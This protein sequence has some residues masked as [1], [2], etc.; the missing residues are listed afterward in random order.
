MQC[1][2]GLFRIGFILHFHLIFLFFNLGLE[3][4]P[5]C[6]FR[7][8]IIDSLTQ[9]PLRLA[10]IKLSES[11]YGAVSDSNGEFSIS[12]IT[13]GFYSLR[14]SLVGY[15]TI[16]RNK[17]H[18]FLDIY[19][20]NFS[21]RETPQF[22][23]TV[24]VKP[25]KLYEQELNEYVGSIRI[26]N[27][28]LQ[29][30]PGNLEDIVKS[31]SILP[32]VA[33][34]SNYYNDL[35]VNGG[36]PSENLFV[37]DGI[38]LSNINHFGSQSN[39]GGVLSYVNMDY[40]KDISFSSGNFSSLYGD[41][42]SSVTEI[43]LQNGAS[44]HLTGKAVVSATQ[45]ALNLNGLISEE[46]SFILS[47]RRS[48]LDMVFKSY[49]FSFAPEYYDFLAKMNFK[50]NQSNNLSLLFIGVLDDFKI[51]DPN[52]DMVKENSRSIGSK[53]D[54]YIAGIAFRSIFPYGLLDLNFNTNFVNYKAL[55]S[56]NF[57][58][59]TNQIENS[60][61]T[62]LI[63][64]FSKKSEL[65][66]GLQ[67][68]IINFRTDI[69]LNR[70]LT[71][72]NEVL[73][74]DSIKTANDYFKSG[75]YVQYNSFWSEKLKVNLGLRADYFDGI[76]EDYSLSPRFHSQYYFSD[77]TSFSLGLGIYRQTPEY[78][79]ISGNPVNK[80]LKWMTA[81][82]L[83]VELMHRLEQGISIKLGGFYKKYYNYPA[84]QLRPYLVMINTGAGVSGADD[85][86]G[87]FG[88][89]PLLSQGKGKVR[90]AELFIQ[91]SP[92]Q[93]SFWGSLSLTYCKVDFSGLDYVSH[94]GSF[95]QR[96]NLVITAGYL[97]DEN[98]E[99]DAKFRYATGTPYTP[100]DSRGIQI[101]ENYN[102]L[103]IADQ[104]SIDIRIDRKWKFNNTQI[105]AFLDIQNIY[106][107][108]VRTLIRW[109]KREMK[110]AED[111]IL[112]IIP[113]FGLSIQI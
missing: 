10:T 71:S 106:N 94:P 65:D 24:I 66:F 49:G 63:V 109:D 69:K 2:K 33:Q 39:S 44:D 21:L 42:I 100:Y 25:K 34:L 28:H 32:G 108:K 112:G 6:T 52:S 18:L 113:S 62:G 95:D 55:Q 50:V 86:F 54:H 14:I 67:V 92:N 84:S 90:G 96:W 40:I 85:N 56:K 35:I 104:H 43:S 77:F 31:V 60:I 8:K 61:K 29:K 27:A 76:S 46:S 11:S 1:R 91:K 58:N 70:F 9:R 57:L 47:A 48:Y 20:E 38:E 41:K 7:G 93:S 79:W 22:T 5:Q 64:N 68:K 88:F 16:I 111:P 102:S 53:Q 97:L 89:E 105:R 23:S 36:G 37:I 12:N 30:I 45:F 82:Q 83:Q 80:N 17:F 78:L 19:N 87:S 59:N 72:F 103:R 75:A 81:E 3:T 110:I 26:E 107:R 98:W 74:T 51:F 101:S 73:S 4:F 15:K 13:P 99:L